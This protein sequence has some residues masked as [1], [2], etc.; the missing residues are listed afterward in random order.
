MTARLC[1]CPSCSCASRYMVTAA[2]SLAIYCCFQRRKSRSWLAA[3]LDLVGT[4]V[5]AGAGDLV[6]S[7][8]V[9]T[10]GADTLS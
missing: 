10:V 3:S 5:T 4:A 2:K 9:R 6:G 8:Q 7:V 1:A